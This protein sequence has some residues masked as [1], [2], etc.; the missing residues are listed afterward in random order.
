MKNL[1]FFARESKP[2]RSQTNFNE[3]VERTLTLRGYELKIENISVD[4][5][6]AENLP[7]TL[8]NRTNSSMFF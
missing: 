8:A 3:M 7:P 2:E 1:L 4:C 5:S 6:L